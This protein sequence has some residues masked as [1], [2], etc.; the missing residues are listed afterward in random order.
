MITVLLDKAEFEYDIHSLVKAFYPKEEVYV[1][2]K[3]KE[4]KEEPVHYHMDVQFAPEEIIFSWKRVEASED[5]ANQTGITKCVA[6]D[7]TN[8]KETK[9]SLKRTLYRL[10]SEYTGVELPWGNLTGIRPTKIPMALLEEG[11]SEEEIAEIEKA[12]IV[13][14]D[15]HLTAMRT[16]RPGIRESD[17]AAAVAEVAF[18]NN[19]QLSFPIIATINGQTLHNHDQIGRAHV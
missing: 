5:N 6:V 16:V 2:T 9:N 18:A 7:Y 13:T 17:V 14:A 4:K 10:L 15:M 1:S 11:K 12:C 19:Y 3:D 8:R